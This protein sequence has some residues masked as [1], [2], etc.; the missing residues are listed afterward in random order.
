MDHCPLS[1]SPCSMPKVYHITDIFGKEIQQMHLCQNCFSLQN[2][3]LN[4]KDI[5]DQIQL[6]KKKMQKA[7]EVENYEIAGMIKKKIESLTMHLDP[8]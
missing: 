8:L 7:V 6:L 3:V 1:N 5:E 4:K 2:L